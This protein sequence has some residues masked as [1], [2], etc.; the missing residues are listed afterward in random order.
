MSATA[1]GSYEQMDGFLKGM[2]NIGAV[3]LLPAV[4]IWF[5]QPSEPARG[6]MRYDVEPLQIRLAPDGGI[7]RAHWFAQRKVADGWGPPVQDN[8]LI[9]RGV[10][11]AQGTEAMFATAADCQ[12]V[13]VSFEDVLVHEPARESSALLA[14]LNAQLAG[15]RQKPRPDRVL[16][17][18][19][20]P[21]K[22]L[23][24]VELEVF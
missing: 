3:L 19:W 13:E 12:A 6:P 18:A 10:I 2:V 24:Y 16:R 1:C 14:A 4:V 9:V 11:E 22:K 7:Q 15:R 5:L 8:S 17:F 23:V 20:C 21:A